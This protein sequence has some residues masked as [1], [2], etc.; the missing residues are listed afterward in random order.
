MNFI[1]PDNGNPDFARI[2][3]LNKQEYRDI[4]APVNLIVE[5]RKFEPGVQQSLKSIAWTIISLYDPAG[6]LCVG[7]WRAPMFRCPTKLGIPI[8]MIAQE[9]N[10]CGL[11]LAL[12]I[13]KPSD[14]KQASFKAP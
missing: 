4:E 8:E 12:R 6:D 1:S 7:K 3:F 9:Q 11:D 10:Y 5:F 13:A 14:I 2:N